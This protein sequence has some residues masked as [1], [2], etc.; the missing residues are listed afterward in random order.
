MNNSIPMK[1]MVN[2]SNYLTKE[3]KELKLSGDYGVYFLYDDKLELKYIGTS[4]V[5]LKERSLGSCH[6]RECT[7][8]QYCVT[9]SKSD[10]IVYEVYFINK[11]KPAYNS[12]SLAQDDL[13][14]TLP[15]IKKTEMIRVLDLT[16]YKKRREELDLINRDRRIKNNKTMRRLLNEKKNSKTL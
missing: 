4:R 5:S 10:A 3:F 7:Y 16:R 14:I 8:V 13:T 11:Y 6:E 15:D 9:K 12:L 2:I 1:H